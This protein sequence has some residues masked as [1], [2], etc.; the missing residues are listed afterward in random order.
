MDSMEVNKGVAAILVAGIAFFV[1][2]MIADGLVTTHKPHEPAIKV[3]VAAAAP[4]PARKAS[5]SPPPSRAR[6][7]TGPMKT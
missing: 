4:A 5:I 2:G 1:T 7:A 6:P 3:E